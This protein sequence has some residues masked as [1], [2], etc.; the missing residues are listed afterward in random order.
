[1]AAIGLRATDRDCCDG[2]QHPQQRQRK[3]DYGRQQQTEMGQFGPHRRR[4]LHRLRTTSDSPELDV[5]TRTEERLLESLAGA[6]R[7]RIH[8]VTT[9][10]RA[11]TGRHRR[12]V[13]GGSH[14]RR[15]LRTTGNVEL[16]NWNVRARTLS[17]K[18]ASA[19]DLTGAIWRRPVHQSTR[20]FAVPRAS[21]WGGGRVLL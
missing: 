15:I 17:A 20:P 13:T 11:A 1:V 4:R 19:V 10:H 6:S 16:Y 14:R 18:W 8:G 21:H 2:E 5:R 3:Y 9:R 12:G 7:C